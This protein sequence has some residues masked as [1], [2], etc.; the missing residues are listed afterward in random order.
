MAVVAATSTSLTY[1]GRIVKTDGTPLQ[2][3][4]VSFLFQIKDPS[5]ACVI[6]QEH[7][8]GINM[9]GSN[10]VFDVPIG[11]GTIS[12]PAGPA[13]VIDV[14]N[15]SSA[16]ACGVCSGYTCTAGSSTYTPL[17]S[18]GRV[19]S[20]SF[21]DGQGWKAIT[22]DT[23]IRA[24]PLAGYAR[25][26][27]KLGPYAASDF[28]IKS[29]INNSGAGSVSCNGGQFLTWDASTLKFGCASVSAGAGGT[30]TTVSVGS[31]LAVTN[32]STTPH[33][34]IPAASSSQ[35][36][37]LTSTDWATF[38]GK[39][40][41]SDL[42]SQ[43]A[44][45]FTGAL[46]GDVSGNQ[47]STSVDKIKGV[48]ISAT[49]PSTNQVLQY[50]GSSWAPSP[51]RLP[52][53]A[54]SV[55][56]Q[57][58]VADTTGVLSWQSL[59]SGTVTA[60]NATSPLSSS[61]GAT[62]TL[63]LAGL[64]SLG[65]AHQILGMNNAANGYEYKSLSGT[66]NQ[67]SVSHGANSIT[68]ST[69]QNIH[70]AAS[71]TFAGLTLSGMSSGGFVKNSGGGVLSGGHSVALSS[72]VSGSL[73]LANGGTGATSFSGSSVIASNSGGTALTTVAGT[74][75][76][77]VLQHTPTG[78]AFS[79]ASFPSTTSIHQILYS[80]ANNVV[81][82]LATANDSV[83]LTNSSGA[84]SFLAK[85]S[86][87]F[88]QYALLAGRGAGQ[89]LY[90]GTTSG[91]DLTLH[92]SS[93]ATKGDILLNPS[94]GR[95][96]VRHTN[97]TAPL[98]VGGDIHTHSGKFAG[99]MNNAGG[100]AFEAASIEPYA[101]SLT[102]GTES[103]GLRFWTRVSGAVNNVMDLGSRIYAWT[104]VEQ[105]SGYTVHNHASNNANGHQMEFYKSRGTHT[106]R[107]PVV[108]NDNY[109][110]IVG[111]TY[112]SGNAWGSPSILLAGVATENHTA[113]GAGSAFV[114]QTTANG[115]TTRANRLIIQHN[116]YV[117]IGTNGPSYPLH[118]VGDTYTSGYYRSPNGAIQTSD[119]RFK[120]N[121]ATINNPLEKLLEIR[122]VTY[123][124]RAQEFPDKKFNER[125][126]LGVI[127]QEVEKQFPEAVITDNEGYK[128]VQYTALVAPLIEAIKTLYQK[129][130]IMDQDKASKAEL[131]AANKEILRLQQEN[132]ELKMRMEKVEKALLSGHG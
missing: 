66:S 98:T 105:F 100:N 35:N 124:W 101:D 77:S 110:A 85:S 59:N 55:S 24:V 60:V 10:G 108:A 49:A 103:S 15:N 44:A 5:G 76:G 72:D 30:V 107:Q 21:H 120:R 104:T 47:S 74:V 71:P 106:A 50:N 102:S 53:A 28:L 90:G 86:D 97:P 12:W 25:S 13:T 73:P 26:A 88:S 81:G 20:V 78:P 69:P 38:N 7:V 116:G 31:P 34:T 61:G 39:L 129:L 89:T 109:F 1:Q 48:A 132:T 2:Y 6:Y 32:A 40:S 41:A 131:E 62:P 91:A 57:A 45:G 119:E 23:A 115:T 111:S 117:G 43:N 3:A 68:L 9:S 8:T 83:L 58:L 82:G 29:D 123:D 16:A 14:F 42:A 17:A 33:I 67:I 92:A 18:D 95:V 11:M 19:L 36:G 27:Q 112:H 22:P 56:G 128:S 75:N 65:S 99:Y 130:N 37:Y 80:S 79:T 84:P 114:F 93:D 94:G 4:N 125:H 46:S 122:G 87:H 51:L 121:I 70:N 52:A 54:P 126:Q 113:T 96:G 127:A 64:S 118:V 63:S